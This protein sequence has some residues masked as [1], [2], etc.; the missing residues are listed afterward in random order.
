[1]MRGMASGAA[2]VCLA[3][4]SAA[5]IP[6][7]S[8][9]LADLGLSR[10]QVERFEQREL[11]RWTPK[12]ASE[13][14]LVAGFVFATKAVPSAVVEGAKA[15]LLEQV[16]PD[17]IAYG[18][19]TGARSAD[20]FA[21]VTLAPDAAKRTRAY[22]AGVDDLNLS[23]EELAA[24]RGLGSGAEPSAVETQIRAALLERLA[25]YRSRGLS[26]IAPYARA[27]GG[28]RSPADELRTAT[29]ASKILQRYAP[30]AYQLLLDYPRAKP[31]GTEE[32]F[33]WTHFSADGTPTLS[34]T[35]VLLVPDGEAWIVAHRQFYV[36]TG[37][38][39][40]QALAAILP[41]NGGSA[42]VYVNRTSTDQV[43]GFGGGTKRSIGS[44]LLAS[45]LETIF[46]RS[47]ERL[48]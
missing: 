39:A 40:E 42:I 41:W 5:E 2:V 1:M 45:Q 37:Y 3:A 25:S 13:R 17:M 46:E 28:L 29:Q 15:A 22:V 24:F 36:S 33:R 4:A 30:A 27:R 6:D 32:T 11:V 26:G 19:C 16:D 43:A 23:P 47:R 44:R 31:P 14:E 9:L 8:A 34:L 7:T 12:A 10:E 20:A 48:E 38:N 35:H 21:G 18:I